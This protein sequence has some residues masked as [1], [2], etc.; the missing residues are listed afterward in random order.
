MNPTRLNPHQ[1]LR[2]AICGLVLTVGAIHCG[3]AHSAI[4]RESSRLEAN[5]TPVS[6]TQIAT[7]GAQSSRI[8]SVDFSNFEYPSRP[9]YSEGELS[10]RLK[11][12]KFE[13]KHYPGLA[14]S[15][16]VH[17]SQKIFGDVTK[18]GVEEAILVLLENVRGS[19]IPYYV[20][21]YTLD[22]EKPRLLWSFSTGDRADGG[23]RRAYSADGDLIV[24]LYGKDTLVDGNLKDEESLGACCPESFTGTRYEFDG[25]K[26]RRKGRSEIIADPNA[27]AD[28]LPPP[29]N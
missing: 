13:G 4:T 20:Y 11:D 23:L 16:T 7:T 9:I 14:E 22:N 3:C 15:E 27:S 2:M 26:F 19:A 28:L 5:A 6:S 18:D 17:L 1:N 21:V 29:K 24:E 10:F 12:G 25:K 8:R